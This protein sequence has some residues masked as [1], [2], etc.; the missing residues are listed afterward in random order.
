MGVQLRTLLG[1]LRLSR[2]V[3][4]LHSE[5]SDSSLVIL[6][7]SV[8]LEEAVCKAQEYNIPLLQVVIRTSEGKMVIRDKVLT[9]FA[10][11]HLINQNYVFYGDEEHRPELVECL[12]MRKGDNSDLIEGMYFRK[13][14]LVYGF[15]PM[16]KLA[17]AD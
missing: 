5:F 3:K 14:E 9:N 4:T 15:I 10:V 12:G 8:D 1:D 7:H 6:F 17:M 2:R 13:G 11:A 16:H